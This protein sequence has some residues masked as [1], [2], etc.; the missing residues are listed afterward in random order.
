M[1]HLLILNRMPN[2]MANYAEWFKGHDIEWTMLA[3]QDVE[4]SYT[5][6]SNALFYRQY[7][8][9]KIIKDVYDLCRKQKP[10]AIV[11][12][13]EFDVL[14][15]AQIREEFSITGQSVANATLFRDKIKMKQRVAQAG[16][17]VPEFIRATQ[18]TDVFRFIEENGFPIIIKPVNGAGTVN[19]NLIHNDS[20]LNDF[21]DKN[22][23]ENLDIES[24][25]DGRMYAVDGLIINGEIKVIWPHAYNSGSTLGFNSGELMGSYMLDADNPLTQRLIQFSKDVLQA[26]DAPTLTAFHCEIFHTRSDKLVLC[27][28]ACR[29]GGGR[30]VPMLNIAFAIDLYQNWVKAQAGILVELPAHQPPPLLAGQLLYMPKNGIYRGPTRFEQLAWV[31][32]LLINVKPGHT[33]GASN[34]VDF[35]A[36]AVVTGATE[37]E[38]RE[39]LTNVVSVF[40]QYMVWE[41]EQADSGKHSLIDTCAANT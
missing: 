29:L 37:A 27:E 19:V 36:S 10:F 6:C 40:D 16:L 14:R 3:W 24:F 25:I 32:E 12:T 31:D 21:L 1:R 8:N 20:E 15:I 11:T 5:P 38:V 33:Y 4:D 39:K 23:I 9:D 17:K 41:C 28:I 26:L 18:A 34:S 30:I 7:T 35:A 13:S 22:V 2:T